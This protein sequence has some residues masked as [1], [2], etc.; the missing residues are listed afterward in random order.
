MAVFP[1]VERNPSRVERRELA[2]LAGEV[3]EAEVAGLMARDPV[4]DDVDE[5]GVRAEEDEVA[6]VV[7]ARRSLRPERGVRTESE[8]VAVH[9][10]DP[11]DDVEQRRRDAHRVDRALAPLLHPEPARGARAIPT[12]D[13]LAHVP[14]VQGGD[15]FEKV[16][17]EV[18]VIPGLD[19]PEELPRV[20]AELVKAPRAEPLGGSSP[21]P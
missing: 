11:F 7:A 8:P 4:R 20:G 13:A 5:K 18:R 1:E 14:L 3:K 16:G 6:E 21:R 19:R 15:V 10:V 12:R 9:R 17:L 2:A